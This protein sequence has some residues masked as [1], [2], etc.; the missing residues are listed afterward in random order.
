VAPH[1]LLDILQ[2]QLRTRV[3]ELLGWR[4]GWY[5][6]YTGI[7]DNDAMTLQ[8][9][10]GLDLLTQAARANWTLETLEPLFADRLQCVLSLPPDAP[11]TH[12]NLPLTPHESRLSVRLVEGATVAEIIEGLEAPDRL[13]ALRV[14]T[15]RQRTGQLSLSGNNMPPQRT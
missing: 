3:L 2:A 11:R 15:M 9:I 7:D 8:G 10:D 4:S 6:L 1:V 12:P 13:A 5:G 14:L